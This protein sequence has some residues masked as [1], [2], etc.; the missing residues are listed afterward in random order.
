MMKKTLYIAGIFLL[1]LAVTS[2]VWRVLTRPR[3][4]LILITLDTTRADHLGV[5]NPQHVTPALDAIGRSGAVFERAYCNVPLTL[6]SHATIMTGRYPPEHG[7]RVNGEAGLPADVT[8]L[9]EVFQA[10][11]YNTAAFVA[12][13]VLDKRFGM[14]QGFDLYDQYEQ[15]I[16]EYEYDA[17]RMYRYRRGNE[18]AD[19]A[20]QW[21][22]EHQDGPFFCWM[23]FFDPHRPYFF[24]ENPYGNEIAFMDHQIGRIIQF[25]QEADLLD[26]TIILAMG[27]HGEGLGE[28]GEEE[29]GLLLYDA[30]MHV[31]LLATGPGIPA[32]LRAPEVVSAVDIFATVNDLMNWK[33]PPSS[34]RSL[35]P[36]LRHEPL[37]PKPV[38]METTFPFFEYNWS[39]LYGLVSNTWKYIQGPED[40]LYD[41]AADPRERENLL[42]IHGDTARSLAACLD[43]Y[44]N[45]MRVAE[46]GQV[47]LDEKDRQ[48][49]ASL[50]YSGGGGDVPADNES[51][52]NPMEAVWMRTDFIRAVTACEEGRYKE[53]EGILRE[54]SE[55]SPETYAFK[56]RLAKLY[57]EQERYQDAAEVFKRLAHQYPDSYKTHYNLGKT[58]VKLR[59]YDAALD[60]L[61]LALR[62]DSSHAD[63]WNNLGIAQ[64]HKRQYEQAV[65]TFRESLVLDPN[66]SDPHNNMGN[67][68]LQMGDP[69]RA[70][71]CF[72]QAVEINPASFEGEFNLGSGLLNAG[73]PEQAIPHLQKAVDLRPDF[74]E[75]RKRLAFA[76]RDL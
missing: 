5:Y 45:R 11:A 67:A 26:N 56:Y 20:L 49:L 41:L 65:E 6:P 39:P 8:T 57:Y 7:C 1:L 31:P 17:Q 44:T 22:G 61:N 54:I 52:R 50:G 16:P 55:A 60:E 19:A 12:S 33:V 3:H 36:A 63:G 69:V 71:T 42:A 18:V 66:Q 59:Q 62:L 24:T 25:L 75:A 34:G 14:D 70:L 13:F 47:E 27:D 76:V 29:H 58:L 37:T 28:H 48:V 38:Y 40:A 46:R 10:H 43:Q 68:Y 2:V 72:Q 9:A 23:H 4:N 74:P 30:T 64:L 15:D 51:L 73:Q 21:L 35:V 32:G 53:A